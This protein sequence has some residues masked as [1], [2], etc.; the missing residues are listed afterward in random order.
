MSGS[1]DGQRLDEDAEFLETGV[2]TDSHPDNAEAETFAACSYETLNR[3][4]L[5]NISSVY[6]RQTSARVFNRLLQMHNLLP[7]SII[8]TIIGINNHFY[9]TH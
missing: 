3:V 5:R 9:C 7:L 1:S 8:I 2:S 4:T 6:T